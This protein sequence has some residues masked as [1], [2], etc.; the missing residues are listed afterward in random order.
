MQKTKGAYMADR[1]Y[2]KQ[3]ASG[4]WDVLKEGDRRASVHAKTQSEAVTRARA[5]V[6]KAGGGEVRVMNRAG[7]IVDSNT[8]SRPKATRTRTGGQRARRS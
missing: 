8:V 6:R 7:K 1:R 5:I 2:V 3:N 4:G